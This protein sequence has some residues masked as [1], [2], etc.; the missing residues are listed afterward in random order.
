MFGVILGVKNQDCKREKEKDHSF[1]QSP[2][3]IGR[4]DAKL[5]VYF[6]LS[7]CG[8]SRHKLEIKS[9]LVTFFFSYTIISSNHPE[10]GAHEAPLVIKL[11]LKPAE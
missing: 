2:L 4:Q 10:T 1:L 3:G 9:L 11:S 5:R 8:F 6:P 7:F